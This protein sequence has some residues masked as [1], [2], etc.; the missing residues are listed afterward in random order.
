MVESVTLRSLLS[1]DGKAFVEAAYLAI[2][3][4]NPDEE[5]LSSALS[6]LRLYRRKIIYL[7]HLALS[8]EAGIVGVDEA[9]KREIIQTSRLLRLPIVGAWLDPFFLPQGV[10]YLWLDKASDKPGVEMVSLPYF[11]VKDDHRYDLDDF[12][13]LYD[14]QL[15][16]AAHIATNGI[17]PTPDVEAAYLNLVR[18]GE[19]RGL[20]LY[21]LLLTPEAKARG[22]FI[23]GARL[24]GFCE[25]LFRIPIIGHIC[26]MVFYLPVLPKLQKTLRQLDNERHRRMGR[27]K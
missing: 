13:G 23:R 7:N 17:L 18:Q 27:V 4:R 20:I 21:K 2:L 10:S 25:L 15:V 22:V 9:L 24:V 16:R 11:K 14:E 1:Q 12:Y 8:K 26:L 19:S 5:G 6:F 3:N